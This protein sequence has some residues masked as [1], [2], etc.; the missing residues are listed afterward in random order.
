MTLSVRILLHY[1]GAL[2]W[3]SEMVHFHLLC[4]RGCEPR[5]RNWE[6][7]SERALGEEAQL[8]PADCLICRGLALL[9]PQGED[10]VRTN[11]TCEAQEPA[12]GAPVRLVRTQVH[13]GRHACNRQKR[14]VITS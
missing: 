12:Q 14:S 11:G 10:L 1:L 9:V 7:N 2:I 3:D 4:H 8:A 13:F 6:R 5:E